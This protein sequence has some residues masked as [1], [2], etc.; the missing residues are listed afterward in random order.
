MG[1]TALAEYRNAGRCFAFGLWTATGYH[2]CRAVEA[3]MRGY[4]RAHTAKD[5]AKLKMWGE[6]IDELKKL[7]S[8]PAGKTLFY[9]EQ[10]KDN[11]RNPLAH[12]RVVL[13]EQDADMLLDSTK[14]VMQLMAREMQKIRGASLPLQIPGDEG[15]SL[16]DL[17]IRPKD[18]NE[19]QAAAG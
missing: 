14:V 1:E 2:A 8:G 18:E 15:P 3:V 17:L 19:E 6:I 13:D 7:V 4:Y 12:V 5:D 16:G 9:L 11:E 10:I